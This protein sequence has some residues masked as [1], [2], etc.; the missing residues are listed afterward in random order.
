MAAFV[1]IIGSTTRHCNCHI[2]FRITPSHLHASRRHL[3]STAIRKNEISKVDTRVSP[4]HFAAT[5][6]PHDR[7][8]YDSLSPAEKHEFQVDVEEFQ[9]ELDSP[10]VQA[11]LNATISQAAN[12]LE[13]QLPQP[14]VQV[15][16]IPA[17][18]LAMSEDDAIGTGPDDEFAD[19]DMSSAGHAELERH[20]EIREY[21]RI[22]AWEMPLLSSTAPV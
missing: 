6:S 22:A 4:K 10:A 5:L 3:A 16:R 2:P 15:E 9:A 21:A 17:G 1:R 8:I 7:A 13:P 14:P 20:R 18:F 11:S 12:E 19:D